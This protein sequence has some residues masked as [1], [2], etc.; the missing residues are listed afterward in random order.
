MQRH[1][2][3]ELQSQRS[4]PSLSL[5]LPVFSGSAQ[6][7][8]QTT[9]RLKNLTREAHARLLQDLTRQEAAPLLEQLERLQ[10]EVD[11]QKHM[12]GLGLFVNANYARAFALPFNVEEKVVVGS[13][14]AT[15]DLEV[16]LSHSPRY[17][18]LVL[19]E[20]EARLLEGVREHLREIQDFDFPVCKDIPGVESNVGG[21]FGVEASAQHDAEEREFLNR[22]EKRLLEV[23]AQR[24]MPLILCGVRRTV[25][26]LDEVLNGNHKAQLNIVGRLD[27]NHSNEPLKV[28]GEK[29]WTVLEE[30]LATQ[31]Q[32][33]CDRLSEAIGPGR[34]ALGLESVWHEAQKGRVDTLLVE[35]NFHQAAV[36]KPN[37]QQNGRIEPVRDGAQSNSKLLPD[38]VDAV[39]DTVLETNGTVVFM[40][41]GQLASHG[42][43]AAILRY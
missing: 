8:Q 40:P 4:F 31:R 25:S 38:A 12:G 20:K 26:Y 3:K 39:V 16:Q 22:V 2:V 43:I 13:S 7:R 19:S 9:V 27:G 15:R 18:V 33:A 41:P 17:R 23:N 14:F 11:T 5:F 24:A 21:F 42:K 32:Q 29:T 37:G 30:H 28:L 35:E 6:D 34:A 1:E 36:Q 10:H